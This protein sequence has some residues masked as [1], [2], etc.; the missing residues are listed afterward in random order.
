MTVTL[1]QLEAFIAVSQTGSF[2]AAARVVHVSQPA[3]TSTI[4][5]LERQLAVRLFERD[6]RGSVLTTAGRELFPAIERLVLELNETVANV[7]N[8]TT[9]SGGTVSIGCIPSVAAL[10]MPPLI[11]SF[12][13]THPHI[14][15]VLKDAMPENRGIVNMIRSGEI[16]YGIASP[17]DEAPDLLFRLLFEDELVALV[18]AV[19]PAARAAMINWSELATMPLIGMSYQSYVRELVDQGF[20]SIGVSKRPYAEVSLITTAVGMVKVGLG[21]TVLPST[22]A[23]VCNLDNVRVLSL[24]KP[25][26]R[27]RM[28]FLYRSMASLSPAGKHFMHFVEDSLRS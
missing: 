18:P 13:R 12:E 23:K 27:R 3:L 1:R 26:V 6:S 8:S 15:V 25:V 11:A 5:K 4:Q 10:V 28:G 22:A 24:E 9:P 17:A 20:A 21:A 2:S 14:R 19:Y 7:L 16:D